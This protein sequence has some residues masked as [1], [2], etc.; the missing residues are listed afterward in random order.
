MIN[1][2]IKD[3]KTVETVLVDRIGGLVTF[4]PG[5]IRTSGTEG[6]RANY[7]MGTKSL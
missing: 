2:N 5:V 7:I 3:V 4:L 6:R 1:T